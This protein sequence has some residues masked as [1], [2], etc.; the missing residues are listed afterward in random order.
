MAEL[1]SPFTLFPVRTETPRCSP[2]L[3]FK[4]ALSFAITGSTET[5]TLEFRNNSRT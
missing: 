1:L 3:T 2:I 4:T 5:S